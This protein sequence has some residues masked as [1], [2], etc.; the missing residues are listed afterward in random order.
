MFCIY[1]YIYMLNARFWALTVD[2]LSVVTDTDHLFVFTDTLQKILAAT[3]EEYAIFFRSHI[4]CELLCTDHGHHVMRDGSVL[5][6]IAVHCS[7]L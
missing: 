4:A 2:H 6:Y 3:P 5:Q 7:V 1:I